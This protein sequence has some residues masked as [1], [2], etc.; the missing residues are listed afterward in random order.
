MKFKQGDR[1]VLDDDILQTYNEYGEEAV[2]GVVEETK[3]SKLLVKWDY[4]WRTPNPEEVAAEDVVSEA[5]ADKILS[6]LEKDY[7]KWAA[8]IRKKMEAA[9]KLL[10]EA[11][12]LATAQRR[13]LA[14]M[15]DI[16]GSLLGAMDE[17]GWR[18]SSLSC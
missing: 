17:V 14:E 8:P 12:E 9:A 7:E 6:K 3:E 13:E 10:K 11:N 5:K 15:H 1:V 16:T 2:R 4:S 18:T